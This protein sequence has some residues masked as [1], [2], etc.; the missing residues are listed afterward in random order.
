VGNQA[1]KLQDCWA[2]EENKHKHP[3]WNKNKEYANATMDHAGILGPKVK[4][5]VC[6][7]TFPQDQRILNDPNAWIA[8]SAA[9][10]NTIPH[11]MGM[12]KVK[13]ATANHSITIGNGKNEKANK[14]ASITGMRCNA[15]SHTVMS[16]I[17][18]SYKK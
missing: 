13:K 6:G 18:W 14:I 11:K 3:T 5:F 17:C 4:F 16:W 7:F 12:H 1:T 9:M 15:H 10:V 8:D 2:L